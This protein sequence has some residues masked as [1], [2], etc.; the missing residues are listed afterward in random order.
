MPAAAPTVLLIG[1]GRLGG[2][3]LEGWALAGGVAPGRLMIRARTVTPAAQAAADRGAML[4]PPDEALARA[5]IVVLAMKPLGLRAVADACAPLLSR[6]A[7][8]VSLLVGVEQA[9]IAQAFDGRRVVRVMP[10]TAIAVG[11]G[12]ASLV[13]TDPD[14]LAAGHA[15]FDPISTTVDLPDE[16]LMPAAAAVSGSGPAYLYAFVEALEAAALAHGLP[17]GIA[18]TLAA[19]TV[20]GSAAYMARSAAAPAELRRQVASPG[21]T[22]EAALKVLMH[23]TR[24]LQPLLTEA[25]GANIARGAQIAAAASPGPR[26]GARQP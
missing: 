5:D 19:A 4:D 2:A 10:T 12:V 1:A 15:L 17:D 24:G 18:R 21:G 25:V 26:K 8:V 9:A 16:A 3:L 20:A 7:I 11:Q 23:D 22:T 14:A 13:S 6:D